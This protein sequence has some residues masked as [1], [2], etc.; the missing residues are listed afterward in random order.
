MAFSSL[1]CASSLSLPLG[2]VGIRN[3]SNRWYNKEDK[4]QR[5]MFEELRMRSSSMM[6][7]PCH[8]LRWISLVAEQKPWSHALHLL[9]YK[10]V[11]D[12]KWDCFVNNP[13][14]W[15]ESKMLWR[16]V[17]KKCCEDFKTNCRERA[18]YSTTLL[19]GN[20][21]LCVHIWT[22]TMLRRVA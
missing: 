13:F 2:V 8:F 3:R 5:P 15:S 9:S 11:F 14:L 6:K 18:L 21:N 12:R 16:L 1:L 7:K 20:W 19:V 10:E 17:F 4:G 22:L